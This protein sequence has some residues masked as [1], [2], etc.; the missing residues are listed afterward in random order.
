MKNIKIASDPFGRSL[1]MSEFSEDCVLINAV[2]GTDH[3]VTVP[4]GA[5][6]CFIG[7]DVG[8]VISKATVGIP[9]SDAQSTGS[10]FGLNKSGVVVEG[11]TEIHVKTSANGLVSCEFY[12]NVG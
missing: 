8:V 7:S 10:E 4:T 11:L 2:A 12:K 3:T 9:A 5:Y 1:Y 6:I